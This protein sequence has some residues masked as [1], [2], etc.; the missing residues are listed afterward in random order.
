MYQEYKLLP[1]HAFEPFTYVYFKF[2]VKL[3]CLRS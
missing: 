2:Y 1:D 3:L